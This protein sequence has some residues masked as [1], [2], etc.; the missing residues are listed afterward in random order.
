MLEDIKKIIR[1]NFLDIYGIINSE[2][3]VYS[4]IISFILL[5]FPILSIFSL[6]FLIFFISLSIKHYI[7]ELSVDSSFINFFVSPADN[8]SLAPKVEKIFKNIDKNEM[9]VCLINSVLCFL[10]LNIWVLV[11]IFL[12]YIFSILIKSSFYMKPLII[13]TIVLFIFLLSLLQIFLYVLFP[14]IL[15]KIIE[16]SNYVEFLNN[17]FRIWDDLR[18]E[19]TLIFFRSLIFDTFWRFLVLVIISS[20]VLFFLL[21]FYKILISNFI[22]SVLIGWVLISLEVGIFLTLFVIDMVKNYYIY[23]HFV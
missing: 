11:I 15:L 4:S 12:I 16:S 3:V 5:T 14:L 9:K 10:V 23:F 18:D 20:P 13:G 8:Y 6:I 2:F 22:F 1:Y 19:N 21:I 17:V 7:R